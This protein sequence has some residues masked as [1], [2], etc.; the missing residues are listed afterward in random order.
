MATTENFDSGQQTGWTLTGGGAAP[1]DTTAGDSFT[2]FLGRFSGSNGNE[3]VSKTYTFT[4]SSSTTT[5]SFDFY[6][7]DS[8][9]QGFYGGN[10]TF[11]VF[12]NGSAAFTFAPKGYSGNDNAPGGNDSASGT[13]T[14]GSLNG[15]Y[16][17]TSSGQDSNLGFGQ[18]S[19]QYAQA[20]KDRIYQVSLTLGNTPTSVKLGFGSTID[21]DINDESYGIDNVTTDAVC[22]ARGTAI[23][24]VRDGTERDV[25]VEHLRVGDAAVTTSGRRRPIRWIG[26]RTLA[27]RGR[28]DAMP[29]RIAAHAFGE[30]RPARDLLI[31]PA[32]ALAVDLLGEVLIPAVRLVNGTTITQEDSE[33]VSYWH[34]ELDGHDILLAEGLPAESYLDCGN[35]RFFAN[36]EATDLTAV[37]DARSVG[38]LPFC[39]PFHEAGPLVELVRDRLRARAEALG[40][41]TVEEPFAGLH[42]VADDRVIRPDI[43]GLTARFVLPADARDVRLVSESSV[44]ADVVPG[45]SDRRR[46]GLPLAALTLDDGLTGTR[47]IALDDPRLGQGFHAVEGVA[48]WTDGSARLPAELW[49]GCRGTVFVQVQLAGPALPRWVAPP[50]ADET[51][52]RA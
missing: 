5:I 11:T 4:P 45:A 35:R 38:P 7:I 39:R 20:F 6:K 12:L 3:A 16:T 18:Q 50:A 1:V 14:A 42:L 30:G 2:N 44:P 24:V 40:W 46:L 33:T 41:T 29:V 49:A 22:F 36:A 31:S 26:H 51:R 21:S 47:R 8:W 37:P 52:R 27:C 43:V 19:G 15:T 13:F 25:A 28:R 10:D 9:D 17:V 34:V 23:R 32:H 48:R